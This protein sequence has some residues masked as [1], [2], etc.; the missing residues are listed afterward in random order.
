MLQTCQV[1][2][3]GVP[4][5]GMP[6]ADIAERMFG[7]SGTRVN[8]SLLRGGFNGRMIVVELTRKSVLKTPTPKKSPLLDLPRNADLVL[9]TFEFHN[10]STV[11][12]L[13]VQDRAT[14][15]DYILFIA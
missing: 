1:R 14:G 13:K 9:K 12:G 3:D 8:L 10:G 2:V 7:P 15:S 6:V 11:Q 5:I 4:C